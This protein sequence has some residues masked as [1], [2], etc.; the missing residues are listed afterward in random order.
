MSENYFLSHFW[1]FSDRSAILDVRNSLSITFLA[2]SDRYGTFYFLNIFTKCGWDD[3]VNYR[4]CPR[5]LD[6]QCMC[7]I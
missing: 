7:Q 1:H 2:I 3:N 5:Y 4:T 6:E